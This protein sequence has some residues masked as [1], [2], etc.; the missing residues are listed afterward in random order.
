MFTV[1]THKE[2]NIYFTVNNT[3]PK[4]KSNKTITHFGSYSKWNQ[5]NLQIFSF[6]I[7]CT[8]NIQ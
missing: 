7:R 3:D 6:L 5:S 4:Q 8:S 1:L 2:K